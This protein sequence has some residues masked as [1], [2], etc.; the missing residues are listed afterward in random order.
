M[1]YRN[2]VNMD[3]CCICVLFVQF[4]EDFGCGVDNIRMRVPIQHARIVYERN[5]LL[6]LWGS[7]A[8]IAPPNSDIPEDLRLKPRKRGKKGGIR[9]RLQ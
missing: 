4:W 2:N 6:N 5:E 3:T 9:A 1:A 7:S 8:A